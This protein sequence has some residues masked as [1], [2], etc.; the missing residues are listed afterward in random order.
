MFSDIID[1]TSEYLE[2]IYESSP[3]RSCICL[4]NL[5]L[6]WTRHTNTLNKS[7]L[8]LSS[9][10]SKYVHLQEDRSLEFHTPGG[11]HDSLRI[12]RYGRD[13]A[14]DRSSTEL[15]VPAVGVNPA[16]MGVFRL[17]LEL[18]RFMNAFEVDVGG[19]DLKSIGGGALQG[20][21]Q[22]GSVN[23]A[24]VVKG[25]HNLLAFGTSLGTVDY[26]DTRSRARVAT[27][28]MPSDYEG[29]PEVTA[30]DFHR[31]GINTAVGTSSGLIYLYDLRS[32]I[33]TLKKDQGYG[34]PNHYV[35]FLT[36]SS[37]TRTSISEPKLAS[38]DRCVLKLWD[39]RDGAP[40]TSV[41]PA[42]DINCGLGAKI[43]VCS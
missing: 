2:L 22:A 16:G 1:Y 7:F 27:L 9:D 8:V 28:S 6:S 39:E 24:A 12:P 17:N 11:C 36:Q 19:D 14:F 5:A 38:A 43:A 21:I 20:G 41:E 29:R 40:W 30:L 33:P 31:S 32:T 18:G 34:Y 13:L 10:Y 3:E 25:S 35:Q 15:L 23:V 26:W 42:V 37:A 4:P